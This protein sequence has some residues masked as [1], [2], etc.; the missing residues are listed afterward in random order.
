MRDFRAAEL[1]PRVMADD[2]ADIAKLE[3]ALAR[4]QADAVDELIERSWWSEVLPQFVGQ[5]GTPGIR[6]AA[7]CAMIAVQRK[8]K[9]PPPTCHM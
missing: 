4:M 2:P 7:L 1:I 5:R 8:A 6:R 9:R 3:N